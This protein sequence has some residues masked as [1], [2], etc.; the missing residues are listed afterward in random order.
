MGIFRFEFASDSDSGA[1]S[2]TIIMNG[3]ITDSSIS[4][5]ALVEIQKDL[6]MLKAG[7]L[8]EW[9]KH[10]YDCRVTYDFGGALKPVALS[11]NNEA[12]FKLHQATGYYEQFVGKRCASGKEHARKLLESVS[13]QK[14]GPTLEAKVSQLNDWLSGNR[15]P[16]ITA[17]E[18]FRFSIHELQ[19]Q[20][21]LHHEARW[22]DEIVA[23]CK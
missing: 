12:Y 10:K 11:E 6:S 18:A 7:S 13:H 4:G 2:T 8:N 21:N 19:E 14:I 3:K 20:L 15:N 22:H 17:L 9:E 1:E 23:Q 16:A 5:S